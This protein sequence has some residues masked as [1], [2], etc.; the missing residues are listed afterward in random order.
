MEDNEIVELYWQRSENAIR[1]SDRKYGR[2]CFKIA[3]N[4][5]FNR[6]DSEE[7]VNDTWLK[8]WES[9][10]PNRPERLGAYLGRITRN[11]ALNLY[12]KLTADKRG[13]G[14]TPVVLD[15]LSEVIGKESDV[16][17]NVDL[18]LLKDTINDFLRQLDRET[19]IIFVQ[20][21]YYMATVKE[22]AANLH[23]S[24][25]KVKMTLLR[26]REKLRVWLQEE[27]YEI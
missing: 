10:P 18:T 12:E 5:L 26:T 22:I 15:E 14:E 8:A 4:V 19:R 9:M 13:A 27:G 20:R 23:L 7:C 24:D 3:Q 17:A 21:Y 2:Y 25:S 16:E 6:S 1:E 11:L